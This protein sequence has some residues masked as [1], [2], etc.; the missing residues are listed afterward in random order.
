MNIDRIITSKMKC[1][2][3]KAYILGENIFL[4]FANPSNDNDNEQ[5]NYSNE[6]TS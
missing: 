4:Y 1:Y 6:N 3:I 2:E 5:G